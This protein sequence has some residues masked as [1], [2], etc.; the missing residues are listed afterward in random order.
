MKLLERSLVEF[1]TVLNE[2]KNGKLFD[3]NLCNKIH[4]DMC[5][6]EEDYISTVQRIKS[7]L[8]NH[9]YNVYQNVVVVNLLD[10]EEAEYITLIRFINLIHK[11]KKFIVLNST[12]AFIPEVYHLYDKETIK[13]I[14][15]S[16]LMKLHRREQFK[17][18]LNSWIEKLYS[19]KNLYAVQYVENRKT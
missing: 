12:L 14:V 8:N 19:I 2:F 10:L 18:L 9:T 15:S 4:K 11:G 13:D 1:D 16:Y 17:K 6:L 5:H 3:L 7:V